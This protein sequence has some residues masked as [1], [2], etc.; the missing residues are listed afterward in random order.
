MGKPIEIFKNDE[1]FQE[2]CKWWQNKLFLNDWFITFKMIEDYI[3][4]DSSGQIL[5][6]VCEYEFNN[7]EATITI[8]NTNKSC[9]GVYLKNIV[10]HTIIH[11]LLHLKNEYISDVENPEEKSFHNYISHQSLEEMAKT[12]LMV[13]YNIERDCFLLRGD[14]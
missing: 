2:C 12:L 11:E 1:Q 3:V 10:E 9:D 14:K 5:S 6:G 13:K 4:D 8:S 7:K